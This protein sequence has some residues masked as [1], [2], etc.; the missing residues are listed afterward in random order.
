MVALMDHASN[1]V[2]DASFESPWMTVLL[3]ALAEV[4]GIVD[5]GTIEGCTRAA[6]DAYT[7]FFTQDKVNREPPPLPP[8]VSARFVQAVTELETSR[9]T[10]LWQPTDFG[11]RIIMA[12]RLGETERGSVQYTIVHLLRT[13]VR[14]LARAI[15]G[16]SMEKRP[17]ALLRAFREALDA[18]IVK[19]SERG[20]LGAFDAFFEV[21]LNNTGTMLAEDVGRAVSALPQEK[22]AELLV[23]LERLNEP[24]VLA[25]LVAALSGPARAQMLVAAAK[26]VDGAP[27]VQTIRETHA[28]VERLLDAGL[29][30]EAER[31]LM[32]EPSIKTWGPV[33]E[34]DVWRF[35]MQLRIDL[36]RGRLQ[37]LLDARVPESVHPMYVPE[38]ERT[39]ELFRGLAELRVGSIERAE[40]TFAR[41]HQR[42]PEIAAYAVN[43][44][45]SRTARIVGD[46]VNEPTPDGL[47][48]HT[49]ERVLA[50][51]DRLMLP[52]RESLLGEGDLTY[53]GNRILLRFA[54]GQY[55]LA[56]RELAA[57]GDWGEWSERLWAYQVIAL[58]KLGRVPEARA[59]IE[60]GRTRFGH[61]EHMC[62]AQRVL[63]GAAPPLLVDLRLEGSRPAVVRSALAELRQLQPG[64]QANAC[65]A[66]SLHRFVVRQ[67]REAC[68]RVRE[69]VPILIGINEKNPKEDR[70]RELVRAFLLAKTSWLGWSWYGDDPGG[71]A[72]KQHGERDLCLRAGGLELA[73]G[74]AVRVF[75]T[76]QKDQNAIC[77]HLWKLFGY[78]HADLMF[79]LVWSFANDIRT[80]SECVREIA[81]R[82]HNAVIFR[83]IR[84]LRL[85]PGDSAPGGFM[86]IHDIQGTLR[87]V[88]HIVVDLKQAQLRSIARSA[89][90]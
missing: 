14:L 81:Q 46:G 22:R 42:F 75:G 6:L 57:L 26:R 17:E 69:Q 37:D 36:A 73:I 47:L 89:R 68:G 54:L 11:H 48:R 82:D 38:A 88:V 24:A 34:R 16:W 20:L 50:D 60:R 53:E 76:T 29:V 74:E 31:L 65:N 10:L 78:T 5:T 63:D 66:E 28:R 3:D 71:Y 12:S 35:R 7:R 52:F 8:S 62:E 15:A 2:T 79:L 32:E 41:L 77:E 45:A 87:H 13:H 84:P 33:E 83:S 4:R 30:D 85:L 67:V 23:L 59:R 90:H 21:T 44:H 51:G 25:A 72:K 86:S 64:E 58:V 70:V 27:S 1:E 9:Q 49:A 55:A 61:T 56:A 43:L 19:A 18:A 39:L 80:V 40:E